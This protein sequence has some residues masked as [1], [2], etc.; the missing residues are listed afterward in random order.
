V[1]VLVWQVVNRKGAAYEQLSD[2]I[3]TWM[4][5]LHSHVS[6]T[7]VV[8]AVTHVDTL[9]EDEVDAQVKLVNKL[10]HAKA[11]QI[12]LEYGDSFAPFSV[13]NGGQSVRVNGLNGDGAGKLRS[14]LISIAHKLPWWKEPLP[15]CYL[16]F[17]N[18]VAAECNFTQK[19]WLTWEKI[20]EVAERC[21]LKDEDLD[22]A[23]LMLHESSA[24]KYFGSAQGRNR[25]DVDLIDSTVFIDRRWIHD[26]FKGLFCTDRSVLYSFFTN[27]NLDPEARNM[28]LRHLCRFATQGILHR[29]LIPFLWPSGSTPLSKEY[30]KKERPGQDFSMSERNFCKNTE[31]YNRVLLLLAG[32]K[33]LHAT[34]KSHFVVPL[35]FAESHFDRLDVRTYSLSDCTVVRTFFFNKLVPDFFERFLIAL[36]QQYLHMD[37]NSVAASLYARG[38]KVQL[39]VHY[40]KGN[41]DGPAYLK[42]LTCTPK[43]M[44]Q[45]EELLNKLLLLC[46]GSRLVRITHQERMLSIR[47]IEKPVDVRI[48][49]SP[50][51]ASSV[52]LATYIK[53][54][55]EQ[56]EASR[57]RACKLSVDAGVAE[58]N[59]GRMRVVLVVIDPWLKSSKKGQKQLRAAIAKDVAIIPLICPGYH[60]ENFGLW[61]PENLQ[62][63]LKDYVLFFDCRSMLSDGFKVLADS[64]EAQEHGTVPTFTVEEKYMTLSSGEKEDLEAMA[65]KERARWMRSVESQ[66]LDRIYKCLDEWRGEVPMAFASKDLEDSIICPQ[67][68]EEQMAEPGVF[69]REQCRLKLRDWR[70]RQN[71]LRSEQ[72]QAG[73]G[74]VFDRVYHEACIHDHRFDVENLLARSISYDA[75]PCPTCVRSQQFPP[76]SFSRETCLQHF[77]ATTTSSDVCMDCPVCESAHRRSRIRVLDILPPQVYISFHEGVQ[78]MIGAKTVMSTQE[79]VQSMQTGIQRLSD[80]LCWFEAGRTT[81][82]LY[83]G[84]QEDTR[85]GVEMHVGATM[86]SVMILFL[87][88]AFCA[89]NVCVREYL[90]AARSAKLII[91][92]L[93]PDKG[94]IFEGGPASGWTGAGGHDKRWWLHAMNC[95]SCRDPDS[96]KSF[97]WSALS[98]FPPIDLRDATD[99]SRVQQATEH[100][101]AKQLL[102][103]LHR[104]S[105]G[106]GT[107]NDKYKA[108]RKRSLLERLDS[109]SPSS[110]AGTDWDDLREAA[111]KMFASLDTNNDGLVVETELAYWGV[112]GGVPVEEDY[113]TMRN[114]SNQEQA[115]VDAGLD[116]GP[117]DSSTT[118]ELMAECDANKDGLISFQELW[119]VLIENVT[120]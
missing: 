110:A 117:L 23:I 48:I 75:V 77:R 18:E 81:L 103:H 66:L 26:S 14:A 88:D 38:L 74:Q 76:F 16:K 102:S 93:V 9:P 24:L 69:S 64:Q 31:D 29:D 106:P 113:F 30:W 27:A 59:P 36:R 104:G 5:L 1:Y 35:L 105:L 99:A 98:L 42:C 83:S 89:S 80:F 116:F 8:L 39:F 85:A 97:T 11:A 28:W 119:S 70:V 22:I 53:Q 61:W 108:L 19:T 112:R 4:D 58:I 37:F 101:I 7:H 34:S 90:H 33:I 17:R 50:M 91:P 63:L 57:E 118:S 72:M 67:C 20:A 115:I 71:K 68:I 12:Q 15:D 114:R 62:E 46:P 44:D 3:S 32:C 73:T 65:A 40:K 60:L 55:I 95:S 84:A 86:S 49:C 47:A 87:S 92:V 41:H 10:F 54:T 52:A 111:S 82:G 21:S 78:E 100:E 13:W 94:P 25:L 56:I 120:L 2:M 107:V 51:V 6:H 45:I 79:L 109:Y 96:G 43:Q